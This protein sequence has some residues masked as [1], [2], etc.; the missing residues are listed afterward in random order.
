M[1][2]EDFND[3]PCL[4]T[5]REAAYV[6]K[7]SITTLDLLRKTKGLRCVKIGELVRFDTKDLQ[8]FINCRKSRTSPLDIHR[9][10]DKVCHE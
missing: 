5:K 6:L 7:I 4:L 1:K 9:Y 3:L 10:Q 8:E 2:P